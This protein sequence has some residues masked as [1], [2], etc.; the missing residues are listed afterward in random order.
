M[1]S[2]TPQR[3][4]RTLRTSDSANSYP[5]QTKVALDRIAVFLG[6]EEVSE[7]VSSLKKD[8]SEPQLSGSENEGLG[9]KNASL[10]W[11]EVEEKSKEEQR[12]R[13][14]SNGTTVGSSTDSET[15]TIHSLTPSESERRFELRDATILFP[16][17]EL[18]VVTGPTARCAS[19][20]IS[21]DYLMLILETVARLL[22]W[23][24]MFT[25]AI[26]I[27]IADVTN[28]IDGGTRRDDLDQWSHHS[29]QKSTSD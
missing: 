26:R 2:P 11:N 7:Q 10:K 29:F 6:E 25:S 24:A 20:L 5:L 27:I 4:L 22:Y 1:D 21:G 12:K 23:S 13:D 9:L 28:F 15:G 17:G 19:Y 3:K 18:T 14:T 16:E 8:L